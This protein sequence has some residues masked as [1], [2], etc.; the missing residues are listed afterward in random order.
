MKEVFG[1]AGK[2]ALRWF[3]LAALVAMSV[4]AFWIWDK[5][6][7]KADWSE[8]RRQK[9]VQEQSVF[10]FDKENYEKAVNLLKSKK[11]RFE[12]GE[13]YSGRDLFFPE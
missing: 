6:I 13:K 8:E 5:Y 11:E 10:S 12:N 4:Y 2:S 7:I 3:Y 9:Y 1:T